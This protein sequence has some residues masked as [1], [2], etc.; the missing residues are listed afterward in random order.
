MHQNLFAVLSN[1]IIYANKRL[2]EGKMKVAEIREKK[3]AF[4]GTF[5]LIFLHGPQTGHAYCMYTISSY[6]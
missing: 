4:I 1:T 2:D 3:G 5:P 6:L